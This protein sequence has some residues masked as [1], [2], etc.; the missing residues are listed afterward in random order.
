MANS[1]TDAAADTTGPHDVLPAL[2]I[3][4]DVNAHFAVV[5]AVAAGN[6][7]PSVD[8]DA[9]TRKIFLENAQQSGL[10]ASKTAP[11]PAAEDGVKAGADD[12][13]KHGSDFLGKGNAIFPVLYTIILRNHPRMSLGEQFGLFL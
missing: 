3:G 7:L 1:G 9:K 11:N 6:T 4:F 5:G 13:R 8:G 2:G 10:R 12:A